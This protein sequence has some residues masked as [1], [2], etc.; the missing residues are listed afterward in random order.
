MKPLVSSYII[1]RGIQIAIM[2]AIGLAVLWALGFLSMDKF[3]GALI[4]IGLLLF[5]L[6]F[7]FRKLKSAA[8]TFFLATFLALILFRLPLE[9]YVG[10]L[11]GQAGS[12]TVFMII[13]F[14]GALAI[15]TRQDLTEEASRLAAVDEGGNSTELI[16]ARLDTE[17]EV[18]CLLRRFDQ[19]ASRKSRLW[20]AVLILPLAML[21]FVSSATAVLFFKSLWAPTRKDFVQNEENRALAAGILCICVCGVLLLYFPG[22]MMSTWWLFFTGNIEKGVSEAL[23]PKWPLAVYIYG[24]GS[25]AHGFWLVFGRR[26]AAD[27]VKIPS[28]DPLF[29][30]KRKKGLYLILLLISL[31]ALGIIFLFFVK[32]QQTMPSNQTLQ[33]DQ[34]SQSDQKPPSDQ[35]SKSDQTLELSETSQS[36][37]MRINVCSAFLWLVFSLLLAQFLMYVFFMRPADEQWQTSS[38]WALM[39]KGMHGV[40]GTVITLVMILAFKDIIQ[41]IIRENISVG[42]STKISALPDPVGFFII[43]AVLAI[44]YSVG[45]VLGSSWGI[46]ALGYIF[47]SVAGVSDHVLGR[48][49]VEALILTATLVNQRSANSDNAQVMLGSERSTKKVLNAIW[50]VPTFSRYPRIKAIHIQTAILVTGVLLSWGLRSMRL[51]I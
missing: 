25:F 40:F 10:K 6:I 31:I 13:L 22:S 16:K 28:A 9:V 47:L 2:I 26:A 37:Q 15:L 34:T 42:G 5:F 38:F 41:D 4:R 36:D 18:F 24:L 23:T 50:S 35:T 19:W 11:S 44:L 32:D 39:L 43:L 1:S 17:I 12:L 14:G 29:D 30:L 33:L 8:L 49:M 48:T 3:W 20:R 46:F 7:I 51:D 45:K 27:N 21:N